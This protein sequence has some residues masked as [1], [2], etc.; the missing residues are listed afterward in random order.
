MMSSTRIIPIV[1]FVGPAGSGKST[2]VKTYSEWLKRE[3]D[4]N[5]VKMNMDPAVEYIPYIPDFDVR[6][7]VNA[8]ELAKKLGLGPN[9]A[10]VRS[11]EILTEYLDEIIDFISKIL[12]DMVLIDTPGQMEVFV[13]R[14]LAPKLMK[15]LKDVS[16][17]RILTLFVVDASLIKSMTDYVFLTTLS[18]AL[19]LRL[20]VDVVPVLNKIDLMIPELPIS[21]D[22]VRDLEVIEENLKGH[23]AYEDLVLDLMNV[24]RNYSKSI[25]I[26]RVSALHGIGMEDLHRIVHEYTCTCGDLT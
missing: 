26:P 21:G 6:K 10:L 22:I 11:I 1:I 4:L 3:Y 7:I 17:N 25:A 18:I 23:G 12:P 20:G 5:V 16:G 15:T 19:Q 2:L 8:K 14:D 24:I 9:G 13:F